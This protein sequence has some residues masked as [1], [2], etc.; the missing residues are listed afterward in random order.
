MFGVTATSAV[1]LDKLKELRKQKRRN[2]AND[3]NLKNDIMEKLIAYFRNNGFATCERDP[4]AKDAAIVLQSI[5]EAR[6]LIR[7]E[8]DQNT[9]L[10]LYAAGKSGKANWD[11]FKNKLIWLP[12]GC[13]AGE[14]GKKIDAN[15]TGESGAVLTK[16][17]LGIN[18]GAE[19]FGTAEML[20]ICEAVKELLCR[21]V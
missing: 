8:A 19:K 11:E 12:T 15:A 18:W 10:Y 9:H 17:D 1:T 20:K 7:L 2:M 3:Q 6:I 5:Q 4:Q 13:K 14:F 16:Y 21:I